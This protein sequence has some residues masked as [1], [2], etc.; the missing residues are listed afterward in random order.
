MKHFI[1]ALSLISLSFISLAQTS[2][3][4]FDASKDQL[5]G[6]TYS[7][8][9]T[10]LNIVITARHTIEKPGP[11]YQYAERYL[12][13]K[14]IIT[15]N[16]ETWQ[17]DNIEI[18]TNAIADPNR[19][20]QVAIDNRGIANNITYTHDNIIVGVNLLSNK[21]DRSDKSDKSD[22]F[23]KTLSFDYSVLNEDAL[24]STSIPK[25]AEM[26]ARQIYRIR[27]S[28]TALLTADLEQLPDGE[29]LK[30]MLAQLDHE[31]AELL[32]FFIGKSTTYTVTKEYRITPDDDLKNYVIARISSTEGLTDASNVIGEPIYL[33]IKGTYYNAPLTD[34]KQEKAPKGFYYNVPGKAKILIES[35]ELTTQTT[36]P[37]AQF[38]YTTHLNA[39]ITNNKT[40]KIHFNPELGTILKIEK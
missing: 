20:F 25:M 26:V 34:P 33:N 4:P 13:T 31:E 38:G 19:T 39:N 28:R 32:A 22:K 27:E 9:K 12:A 35:P 7:L 18:K 29:A 14:E 36:L 2:V 17:I 16:N 1:L 8:P 24:V 15:I 30:T 6:I 40:A 5:N 23:N 21:S 37:I 11:F 10:E 3:I